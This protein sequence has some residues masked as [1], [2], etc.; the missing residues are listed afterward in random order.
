MCGACPC[1]IRRY[2]NNYIHI[3]IQASSYILERIS[4]SRVHHT[5]AHVCV[6]ALRVCVLGLT[7]IRAEAYES[8][9][10]AW[11]ACGAA[12]RRSAGRN[13]GST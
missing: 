4:E 5:R 13:M 1:L 6:R 9:T 10:S 11:T 8:L 3:Y 7:R 2:N 12:R